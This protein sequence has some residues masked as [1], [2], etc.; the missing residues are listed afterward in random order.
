M[1]S[2]IFTVWEGWDIIASGY[3]CFITIST[4]GFGDIVPGATTQNKDPQKVTH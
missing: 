4:I 1:G 3:Y 2:L